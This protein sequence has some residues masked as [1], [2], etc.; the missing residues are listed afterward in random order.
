M[1]HFILALGIIAATAT[2]ARA[3]TTCADRA[4][5]LDILQD[6]FGERLQGMGLSA[7]GNLIEITSNKATGTFTVIATSPGGVSCIL[8]EGDEFISLAALGD[9]A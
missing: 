5:I 4:V 1:K 8:V 6:Q 9:P 7:T 3:D 2:A